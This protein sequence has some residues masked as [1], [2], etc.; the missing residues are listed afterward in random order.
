MPLMAAGRR[1]RHRELIGLGNCRP[2]AA[3]QCTEFIALKAGGA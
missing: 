1:G 2:N 3:N